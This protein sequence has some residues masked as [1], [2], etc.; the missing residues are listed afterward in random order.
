MNLRTYIFKVSLGR[1]NW[2][3]I[4]LAAH[5]TFED[6][7]LHI[8]EAFDLDNDHLYSFFMDGKAWSD[9]RIRCPYEEEGIHTKEVK[10]GEFPLYEKQN[11]L[12]LY[13]YG[14]EWRFKVQVF[15]ISEES[16]VSLLKPEII[17]VKGE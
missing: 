8:L 9:N 11:F 3:K 4:K 16:N 1:S 2:C 6:L 10:V 14:D 7:H 17:E 13:D 12:Y 15:K 5:H